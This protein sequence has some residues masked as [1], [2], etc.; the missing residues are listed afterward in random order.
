MDMGADHVIDMKAPTEAIK[1]YTFLTMSPSLK[2]PPSSDEV[3]SEFNTHPAQI[4]SSTI[5]H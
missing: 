2:N 3:A 1:T 4:P 5:V